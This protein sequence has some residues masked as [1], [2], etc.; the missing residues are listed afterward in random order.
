MASQPA[1][2]RDR[3]AGHRREAAIAEIR[4]GGRERRRQP[5]P[6]RHEDRQERP[7]PADAPG[8]SAG[9][10][11]RRPA[12]PRGAGGRR[13]PPASPRP[14]RDCGGPGRGSRRSPLRRLRAGDRATGSSPAGMAARRSGTAC[15]SARP[16]RR[17]RARVAVHRIVVA[18][19]ERHAAVRGRRR[20]APCAR[21]RSPDRRPARAGRTAPGVQGPRRSPPSAGRPP[22]SMP[23][24]PGRGAARCASTARRSVSAGELR[25][26]KHPGEAAGGEAFRAQPLLGL[27]A[28]LEGHQHRWRSGRQ[29]IGRGVVA[30]LADRER[31][32][33]QER[34]V[35]GPRPAEVALRP[36]PAPITVRAAPARR[37]PPG[38][39]SRGPAA[40]GPPSA[41]SRSRIRPAGSR[42]G[43]N[44]HAR[45]GDAP[46]GAGRLRP[47]S[48]CSGSSRL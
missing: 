26:R 37:G 18:P 43:G 3:R 23:C 27:A 15:A 35:V 33:G 28:G 32:A 14:G 45:A 6:G 8:R 46:A 48:R 1:Q 10:R 34:P 40:A 30:A 25:F 39:A 17:S 38:S 9:P 29:E 22:R 41:A 2:A 44:Q 11:R 24:G 13:T 4:Q 42:P 12:G 16:I 21:H 19:E 5:V 36:G 20:R 47:R 7:P 31:G